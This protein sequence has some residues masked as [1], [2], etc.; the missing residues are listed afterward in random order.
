MKIVETARE[1]IGQKEQ[2]GNKFDDATEL[3]QL[4]HE[5]GQ[6][7]GE[8]WCSYFAEAVCKKAYP[9]KAGDIQRLFSPSAV[10][11]FKN[12]VNDDFTVTAAP[13]VGALVIWRRYQAGKPQWQGH[14]GIVTEVTVTGFKSVEG[15]SNAAGSRDSDSVV[16]NTRTDIYKADGLSVMGFID[17]NYE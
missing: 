1:F 9:H 10:K 15:N 6:K 7:D 16:E 2:P 3:G 8:A 4:I 13:Q 17:L 12:F 5:A 11:T 14:A